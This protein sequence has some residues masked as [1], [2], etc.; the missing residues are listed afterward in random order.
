MDTSGFYALLV[1]EDPMHDRARAILARATKTRGRFVTSD[2]ILDE[3]ATLLRARGQGHQSAAFFDS[4]LRSSACRIE[5]MNAER[6]EET[7]GFFI[8]HQDQEWSF[9]DCFS[10]CLLRSLH[11]RDALSSDE[12]FR[13]AGFNP[14]LT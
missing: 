8:K 7:R 10:F 2:Y 1:K 5:W 14:L 3:T 9:T 6:F 13:H 4:V 12:H 11:L